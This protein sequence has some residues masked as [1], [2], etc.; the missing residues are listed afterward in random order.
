MFVFV[1]M[2]ALLSLAAWAV[3]W[4]RRDTHVRHLA[5]LGL[6]L[7]LPALVPLALETSGWHRPEWAAWRLSGDYKVLAYKAVWGE[8]IYLYLDSPGEPRPIS[9]PWSIRTIHRIQEADQ[10]S[11]K[12][13]NKRGGFRFR[14]NNASP[15]DYQFRSLPQKDNP[16]PK[17]DGGR[18]PIY[19]RTE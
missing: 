18:P 10:L 12:R 19:E 16:P 5:V 13:G 15:N 11:R 9:L 3:I 7:A 8:G 14:I 17:P 1:G 2:A 4:S 6:V